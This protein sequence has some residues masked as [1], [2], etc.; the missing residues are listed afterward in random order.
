[1]NLKAGDVVIRRRAGTLI[2]SFAAVRDDGVMPGDWMVGSLTDARAWATD[3]VATTK[4]TVHETDQDG[5]P[6][7]N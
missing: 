2:T 3:T 4:A 6:F 1:M 7:S 5:R